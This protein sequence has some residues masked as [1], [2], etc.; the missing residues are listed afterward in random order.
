MNERLIGSRSECPLPT[1]VLAAGPPP[2][3]QLY[4]VQALWEETAASVEIGT[5]HGSRFVRA[6]SIN[7]TASDD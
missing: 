5:L 7:E 4:T 3:G 1:K 2:D 6:H